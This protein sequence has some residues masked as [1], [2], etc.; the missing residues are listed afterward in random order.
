MPTRPPNPDPP[1]S[2]VKLKAFLTGMIVAASALVGGL[3]VVLYRKTLSG[4]H[5]ES[6]KKTS[7]SADDEEG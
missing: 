5:A 6:A 4:L 1:Q 7:I 3:A 2:G